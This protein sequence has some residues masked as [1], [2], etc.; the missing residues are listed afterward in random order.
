MRFQLL[1]D[2]Q[3]HAAG[4]CHPMGSPKQAAVFAALLIDAGRPL[5][6]EV[7]VDRVW[8]DTPHER[9][10][11]ALHTYVSR[12]RRLLA[13]A[14]PE[15]RLRHHQGGGYRLELPPELVDVHLFRQLVARAAGLA[16]EDPGRA[17]LLREAVALWG[18]P[19][20][21]GIA[22]AWAARVRTAL[23][24]E[25]VDALV[26]WADAEL[27]AGNA[28]LVLGPVADLAGEHPLV[29]P[30]A[31][32]LMRALDAVGRTGDALH[33]F[34]AVR[35]RLVDELGVEP[36]PVLQAAHQAIL[37]GVPQRPADGRTAAAVP[38]QLPLDVPDFV[39]RQA[40]QRRMDEVVRDGGG[41]PTATSVI[42]VSGTAGVGKSALVVH[43]GH[44]V[45][46]LFPDGQLYV[47]LLGFDPGGA[48]LSPAEALRGF[49]TALRVPAEQIPYGLET[50]A[51]LYRSLLAD[52]QVLVVLDNAVSEREVRPLLPG[53]PRCLVVVASR[54]HLPGLVAGE[55]A[56]PVELGVLH[57]AE[58][59]DL[60]GRRLGERR[61]SA[62]PAAVDEI[63][64]ACA[65]LPLA[66]T[67]AAARAMIRPELTLARLA[68]QLSDAR[69]GLD[70]FAED[71]EATDVRAVLSW[72][73]R[74]L[75]APQARLLRLVGLHAGPDVPA[76]AAAAL[77]G[78]P[79]ETAER[80]IRAL[81]RAHLLTEY[82]PGRY[83]MHDLLRA[84]ATELVHT[85]ETP[86]E[87]TAARRRMLDH[88]LHSA[89]AGDRLLHPHR[90]P[91]HLPQPAAT[92][93]VQRF[94]DGGEALAWFAAEHHVLVRA[95]RQAHDAGLDRDAWQLSWTL[96]TYFDLRGHW[97]EW[98]DTQRIALAAATRSGDRAGQA[99]AHRNL[100]LAYAQMS[101]FE[102]SNRHLGEALAGYR[103]LDDPAGQAHTH[104]TLARVHGSQG[105]P[106]A[107]LRE[108]QQA[109]TLFRRA[110][111]D[112]G[113]ARAL[114]NVGWYHA[115][116]GDNEPALAR[117]QEALVLHRRLGDR[118]G[119]ANT[120]DSLGLVRHHLG[121][122]ERAV[123]DYRAALRAWR[124][125]GD[126]CN[127]AGTLGRIGETYLA[128]GEPRQA[129]EAWERALTILVEL[130]HADAAQL[131]HKLDTQ[132]GAGL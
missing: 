128:T 26:A 60:L 77:L 64:V 112:A 41:Q 49:L 101:A 125:V 126:R 80:R 71:D 33:Q 66:L 53:A 115:Q 21:A 5:P 32:V 122:Y 95:V 12:I 42:V 96:T 57:P 104:N 127:E 29:E 8:G 92:V 130:G 119:E 7:L 37:G 109:T 16:E 27:R 51:A 9:A 70:A 31:A 36:G 50:R 15:A 105:R 94:G 131:R 67:V 39:G 97:Q 102:E 46:R 63:V 6:V 56:R 90:E 18:G 14:G 76:P 98:V 13:Q 116:L 120:L 69:S 55:G 114:N 132:V 35:R 47:D 123:D 129:R 10:H 82:P 43:W 83:A 17:V 65:G 113:T 45:R 22:G 1:G 52:R 25:R 124:E 72:S 62:E 93:P 11:R 111:H 103:A 89:Y 24:G 75:D 54:N 74:A 38:A 88:Y 110:G 34:L 20:L 87:V 44:R 68:G 108:S 73:Y 121:Q 78:E 40:E 61:S 59:R 106:D 81:V 117:C 118:Y 99:F 100:G 85:T 30:L 23:L 58:A 79:V 107:A 91:L 2:P 28:A 84:Y 86:T 4:Q 3:V 48:A 19:P